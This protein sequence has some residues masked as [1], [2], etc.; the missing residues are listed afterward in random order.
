MAGRTVLVVEDDNDIREMLVFSLQRAGYSVIEAEDAEQALEKLGSILPDI[1][2]VD[3]MLPG[4]EG[5][6]ICRR[7]R[8]ES[9]VPIIMVTA[10]VEEDDRLEGLDL[11]ADDY[12]TK[13]FSP[14][15]LAARVRAVLRRTSRDDLDAGP[16]EIVHENVVIKLR[17]V[18][19]VCL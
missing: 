1:I 9:D 3:W 4:M 8:E 10:R 17:D 6:E 19:Q 15:E 16:T 18:R 12:L 13:P 5:Q 11:G 7:V 14:R 2:L